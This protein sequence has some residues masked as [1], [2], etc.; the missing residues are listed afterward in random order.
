MPFVEPSFADIEPITKGD[1]TPEVQ[2]VC[3]LITQHEFDGIVATEGGGGVAKHGYHQVF[4]DAIPVQGEDRTPIK[5][6][7][8]SVGPDPAMKHHGKLHLPSRRYVRLLV[9]GAKHYQLEP[10]YIEW[11]ESHTCY[12][13]SE[14]VRHTALFY[15]LFAGLL[16][17]ALP[18]LFIFLLNT[19]LMKWLSKSVYR[20]WSYVAHTFLQTLGRVIWVRI[21]IP[22]ILPRLLIL[23]L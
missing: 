11:L 17:L 4:V 21:V 22:L 19:F 14:H 6:I 3:H 10:Q 9:D 7:S 8:L 5:A 23:T 13:R 15:L 20:K 12:N 16:P 2:G 1:D 18:V